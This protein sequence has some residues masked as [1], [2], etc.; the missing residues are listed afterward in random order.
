MVRVPRN[1][2]QKALLGLVIFE[3]DLQHEY[4]LMVNRDNMRKEL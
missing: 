3:M 1:A 4:R 2:S